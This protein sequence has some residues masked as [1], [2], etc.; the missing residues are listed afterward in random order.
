MLLLLQ[1]VRAAIKTCSRLEGSGIMTTQS[2]ASRRAALHLNSADTLARLK[3][4][5]DALHSANSAREWLQR[6]RFLI[7][8][9]M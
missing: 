1:A 6:D 3:R 5:D 7:V 4:N 9:T 8:C 2:A